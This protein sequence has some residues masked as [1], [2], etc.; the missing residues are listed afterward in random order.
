MKPIEPLFTAHL[1]ATLDAKLIALLQS[2]SPADWQKQTIA[3][4]WKVKDVAVHLLDGNI[5][6]LSIARDGYFGEVPTNIQSYQD[7]VAFLNG[8]NADWVK[9][10]RRVS[11][12]MLVHLLETTGKEYSDYLQTLAPFEQA[13]FSVAWA[14]EEHSAN[15][16]HI[17]REYT[18]KWHH[19]QQIR[20]AV[21][22]TE[23]LYAP[24]LYFPHLDTSMRALPHHYRSMT[25]KQGDLL[26][27][28]VENVGKWQLHH[29]GQAWELVT[30]ST[31]SSM[32][33]V[34]IAGEV[35]WRIFTKGIAR[36]EAQQHIS[37]TGRQDAGEK[38]LD[39]LAVMA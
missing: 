38:I 22:K 37:I 23:E 19:Q 36:Q 31:A 10:M 8:L 26:H 7:L 20:L 11:P 32:C 27:F 13:I 33:E 24:E 35:A 21:G 6:G 5:R 25:G 14:G 4:L 12:A 2:L 30:D 15:W 9:A 39:M 28:I 1:F 3:P 34:K 29:N 16:F 17:A 18:E